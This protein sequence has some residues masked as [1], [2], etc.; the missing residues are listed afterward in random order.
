MNGIN[1][2]NNAKIEVPKNSIISN[3][4]AKE[5]KAV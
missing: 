2:I 5:E 3:V 4:T 1:K